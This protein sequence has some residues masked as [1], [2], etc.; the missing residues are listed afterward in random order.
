M[1]SRYLDIDDRTQ[2]LA[3]LIRDRPAAGEEFLNRYELS[4]VYHE[5]ALEG[6]VF[7]GD[8]IATALS[9]QP[10]TEIAAL[11]AFRDIRN[12]KAAIEVVRAEAAG[13]KPRLT[14]ALVK[15][16]YETLHAGMGSKAAAELRRDIPL[17]R[18]YFHEIEQPSRIAGQLDA[19]LEWTDTAEFRALHPVQ[20]ASS[21]HH[22]FMQVYPYTEGSGKIARLLSNLLLVHAAYQPCIIHTIDRQRYYESLKLPEPHLRDLMLESIENALESAEKFMRAARAVRRR[23]AR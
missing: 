21:V 10:V 18:A 20:Q 3:D 1:R 17:H 15:R 4:W 13:R 6:V 22:G 7:S 11:N 14:L 8:E 2:D 16:L 5:N 9:P 12:F 23:A 19:L